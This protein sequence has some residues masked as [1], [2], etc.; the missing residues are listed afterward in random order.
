MLYTGSGSQCA[1]STLI[2]SIYS[3]KTFAVLDGGVKS[4]NHKQ[5]FGISQGC[6][7]SPFLF[8]ML[9]TILLHDASDNVQ[10]CCADLS[11]NEFVFADDTLVVATRPDKTKTHMQ[12]IESAGSSCGLRLGELEILPVQCVVDIRCP[13]GRVIPSRESLVYFGGLLAKSGKT[14]PELTTRL[15][16]APREFE[17]LQ[18]VWAHNTLNGRCDAWSEMFQ[19]VFPPAFLSANLS[20]NDVL[21]Q[22]SFED[23]CLEINLNYTAATAAQD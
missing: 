23:G 6:P 20:S 4:L 10:P 3:E 21:R 12:R 8:S 2:Q 15:G 7:L 5:A 19:F 11:V 22:T 9:M 17:Q 16:A 14:G 13:D 18:C 1:L